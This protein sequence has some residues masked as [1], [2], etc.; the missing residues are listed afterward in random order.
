MRS[1]K[2]ENGIISKKT[3]RSKSTDEIKIYRNGLKGLK[4]G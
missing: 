1:K 3:L 2:K 4:N